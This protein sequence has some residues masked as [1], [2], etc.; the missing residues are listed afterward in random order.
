MGVDAA[1]AQRERLRSD[2]RLGRT[3]HR[4]ESGDDTTFIAAM[5]SAGAHEAVLDDV[6]VVHDVD[7]GRF[8][9][10]Y[11]LRRAY[12]QGRSEVRRGQ[13]VAGLRKEWNRYIAPRDADS[14]DVHHC[15]HCRRGVRDQ[16][17]D[18]GSAP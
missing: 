6:R 12:W 7:A 4:L 18:P 5:K 14:P 13:P 10:H 9:L 17:S 15:L 8:T 1:F 16:L 11:I 2:T 3:G